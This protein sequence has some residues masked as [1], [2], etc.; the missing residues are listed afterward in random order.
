MLDVDL[1]IENIYQQKIAFEDSL[2]AIPRDMPFSIDLDSKPLTWSVEEKQLLASD[3]ETAWLTKA[4]PAGTHCRPDGAA[5]GK[6]VKLGWAYNEKLSNPRQDLANEAAIDPTFPEI[7]IRGAAEFIPSLQ[8][9]IAEPPSV[10]SHYGGY[11]TMTEENWPLI[12]PLD[13]AGAFLVG[14]L[15][16]FGSMAACAAGKLCAAHVSGKSLPSYAADLSLARYTNASLMAELREQTSKG[17]L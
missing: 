2:K 15:S 6:R 14:A 4:L 17:L 16:G 3:P 1:P 9:Y 11:Y 10:F 13:N 8:S 12:G 7:V 5:Q